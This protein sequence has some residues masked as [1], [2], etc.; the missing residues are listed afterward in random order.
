MS[1]PLF[2]KD[3]HWHKPEQAFLTDDHRT[4]LRFAVE[5]LMSGKGAVLVTLVEIR[6][7]AARPLGAQMVVREDGR[8]C[9]FVSGGCV[10]AAAAFEALEMMGSG[11][12][13][14]IRYGEGSPWFDIVLPCGGGITLTLH[15]LRSAQPLLAVLNRLEQRKPV[16]LR[17]DP[18]A[19]SLVCLPTQTRTGWNL[20]GFE[21][22][23]RPCVRLMI[24]GRS[25]E[26]QATASLAAATGYDSHI[27]D[28]FPASASAQIDT[29]TAVILLCH[30]LNREL[31]VLQ[32]ARE[33]KPFYLGALGSYRT[34]TLRLQ[35][36]HELGWSREET[37]QIRA[38]VGIF[39]KARDA[40]T[41]ALSVLAEVASVRLHQEEDSCL[42]PV[43]LILAA[44]RG[45][46]FLASGGN[47]H[48]CIGW[49]QSPEVAPYRWPFEENGRTFD[50]AIEPQITTNDLRLMLRL[51]LAGGGIT[52][53]TQETFRPYI[54][55]GK[56]VS[57]LDDFLPQFP[58]FYL[59]FPQR[60]NIAPKLRALIDYVKEWRQQL[61]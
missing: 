11:R 18:Q 10:E 44:G 42:P 28:L 36:L 21:V 25:L 19:Q 56:L 20:N 43:V 33:A 41:L 47:T 27:F 38:P 35:K 6:G 54:E 46:R 39:P 8:Y 32:A 15:K 31:P 57:L 22:G 60:R 59:Y 55:S 1:Y 52:I 17:Y 5:A 23:F 13:R 49:R 2:D 12:D 26:A 50:L 51:A 3:E 7:G 30:D 53:A 14:E 34:H 40:H 16:G 9:G 48:K 29:D 61:A 45:E 24:Y 4:I 37:T 58:G